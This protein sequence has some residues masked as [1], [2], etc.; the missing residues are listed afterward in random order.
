M[1]NDKPYDLR[2]GTFKLSDPV[3]LARYAHIPGLRTTTVED[4]K[5]EIRSF[6]ATGVNLQELYVGSDDPDTGESI[7]TD[8]LPDHAVTRIFIM[9]SP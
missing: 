2:C 3:Y 4:F 6:F 7:M 5:D 8:E 9:K 1:R